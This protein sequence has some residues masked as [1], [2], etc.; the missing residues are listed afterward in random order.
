MTGALDI[1]CSLVLEIELRWGEAAT[2][3]QLA[4][5]RAVLADD[6]PSY[7]FIT[8]ARG[9]SK[10]G[11]MAGVLVA[12]LLTLPPGSRLYW[13]AADE[14]QGR[15]ALDSIEGY[16]E[17]TDLLR[18][19]LDVQASRV[20]STTTGSRLDVLPADAASSWGLR[21]AFICVDEFAQWPETPNARRLWESLSSAVLKVRGA[22]I[23]AITTAGDPR[24]FSRKILEHA[25]GSDLWRVSEAPG[26]APWTPADRLAEQRA[27]LPEAVYRQL[28]ENEWVEAEGAF[29]SPAALDACFDLPGPAIRRDRRRRYFAGLDLGHTHD[30]TAAAVV[31]RE[32][33]GVHLDRLST[34]SGSR[35]EPVSFAAVEREIVRAHDEFRFRLSADPWQALHVLERLRREGIRA[36][37]VAFSAGL[38][39][40]LASTLLQ[41]VNDR[42]LHLYPDDE[43]RDELLG[44][45][46]VQKPG[47]W[48]F[49]H[50]SGSH[51]DRAIALS[52]AMVAALDRPLPSKDRPRIRSGTYEGTRYYPPRVGQRRLR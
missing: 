28:F 29:L 7:H 26:P 18:G 30:R 47:G 27:R 11:D 5:A 14:D 48:T 44:L 16:L 8:R 33:D 17:R 10:T 4:D 12:L 13:L 2:P 24:H 39:Q 42:A 52:L 21:P 45:H 36:E 9:Y 49:D 34:W 32:A 20:V 51:D 43:L 23:A 25:K 6:S 38:K 50:S 1:L 15:L 37:E 22:R 19:A 41:A 31:H 46:L 35:H 40:R 3:V